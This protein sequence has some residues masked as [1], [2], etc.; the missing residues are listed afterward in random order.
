MVR[1]TAY[2]GILKR[3]RAELHERFAMWLKARSG[4][5]I[6]ELTRDLAYHLE[7][8]F[9]L[10]RDLGP[11]DATAEDRPTAPSRR[12]RRARSSRAPLRLPIS[13][14]FPEARG[15][16]T[17]D[18]PTRSVPADHPSDGPRCKGRGD[19]RGLCSSETRSRAIPRSRVGSSAEERRHHHRRVAEPGTPGDQL[20]PDLKEAC[21]TLWLRGGRRRAD[22]LSAAPGHAPRLAREIGESKRASLQASTLAR[23]AGRTDLELDAARACRHV[24]D[25]R[26]LARGP[27]DRSLSEHDPRTRGRPPVP[28][29]VDAPSGNPDRGARRP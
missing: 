27:S 20:L 13:E 26:L 5:R 22:P 23:V 6:A 16:P 7:Q 3:A 17:G 10:R 18:P 9:V 29:A 4:D 11:L 2:E 28:I 14:P 24:R 12:S 8:A 21:S 1:D 15:R 25:V 19:R